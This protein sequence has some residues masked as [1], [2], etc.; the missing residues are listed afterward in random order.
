MADADE[1][2]MF[3]F[4]QFRCLDKLPRGAPALQ[5]PFA[6]DHKQSAVPWRREKGTV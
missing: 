5:A 2:R 4:L 1:L 6:H 3:R